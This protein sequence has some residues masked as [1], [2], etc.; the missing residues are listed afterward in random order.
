M[1][2]E[3][4]NNIFTRSKISSFFNEINDLKKYKIVINFKDIGFIS[5][6]SADEYLNL[7]SKLKK[8]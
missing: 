5:R 3:F 7:K 6:S 8:Q 1:H 2:K 4:G